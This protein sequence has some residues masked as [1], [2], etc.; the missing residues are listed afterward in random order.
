MTYSKLLAEVCKVSNYLR[1]KGVQRGDRVAI[2]MPMIKELVI[3]MLAVARIG[4]VHN[5]IVS[6]LLVLIVFQVMMIFTVIA[7][8]MIN[9]FLQT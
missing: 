4:A 1:S 6:Q 2:Y 8:N 3:S 9:F 5:I 7:L